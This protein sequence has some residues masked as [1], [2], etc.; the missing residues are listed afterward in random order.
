M[1]FDKYRKLMEKKE[2]EQGKDVRLE[3]N[4]TL[5]LVIAAISVFLPVLLVIF[6]VIAAITWLFFRF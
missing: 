2:V 5:A 6:A 4:D 3:K 1:A